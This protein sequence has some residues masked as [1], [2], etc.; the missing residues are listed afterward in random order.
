[1]ACL[2]ELHEGEDILGLIDRWRRMELVVEVAVEASMK[3]MLPKLQHWLQSGKPRKVNLHGSYCC[4][5]EI[6]V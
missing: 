3:A 4:Q 1:M 6:A 5:V 2:L